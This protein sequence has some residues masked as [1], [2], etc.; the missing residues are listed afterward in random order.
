MKSLKLAEIPNAELSGGIRCLGRNTLDLV[1]DCHLRGNL[2]IHDMVF[3]I[4]QLLALS[5]QRKQ[6]AALSQ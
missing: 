5:C 2:G 4:K 6:E 3:L 1:A